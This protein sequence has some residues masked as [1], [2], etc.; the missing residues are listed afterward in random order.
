MIPPSCQSHQPPGAVGLANVV[1]CPLLRLAA[2]PGTGIGCR[3]DGCHQRNESHRHAPM[4]PGT[5][6]HQ[7]PRRRKLRSATDL[8]L[9]WL[10]NQPRFL[11][12]ERNLV[13]KINSV[14]TFFCNA[15]KQIMRRH[16][17]QIILVGRS[18]I[19]RQ[20]IKA[21]LIQALTRG[22]GGQSERHAVA[23]APRDRF[24]AGASPSL[25]HATL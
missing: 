19:A 9:F 7:A 4:A 10:W 24:A 23:A 5:S 12:T 11:L 14:S 22:S 2:S 17:G 20:P 21:T 3:P 8:R 1:A 18:Q 15:R 6:G 13:S 25:G 16:I